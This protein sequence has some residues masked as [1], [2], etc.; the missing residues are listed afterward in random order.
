MKLLILGGTL[1]LGR[2]AVEAAQARGHEVTL[3]NRGRTNPELFPEVERLRGDR[4]GGLAALAGRRW[5]AVLD[6]SGYLPN[7]VRASCTLL[8]EAVGHYTFISSINVYADPTRPGLVESDALAVLKPGDP[9]GE[10]TGETYGPLKVL[11]EREVEAA[12]GSRCAT[13]RAGL[14]YGPH[15]RTER[16]GYWPL[17]VA[18]GGDVLAP[19]RP[20]RPVQ[21]IDVRDLAAWLVELAERGVSGAFNATGPDDT[22]TMERF[23]ETCREVTRSDARLVWMDETFLLEQKAGPFS[24]L[25]LWVPEHFHAVETVN[26][27]RAR[28][29]GLRCRPLAET[30]GAALEWARSLPPR[31]RGAKS[32]RALTIPPAMTREREAEL[33]RAWHARSAA[34]A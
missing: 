31:E 5:D 18:E 15:D 32:G 17:R 7:V 1:F 29:A 13:V 20:G 12:F 34:R 14:I 33:L 10:V 3:F 22:L 26:C 23:L 21:L 27:T 19:G 11:C 4:E 6:P 25:P 24:E 8:R 16:T 2:H 9:S 28:A 30:V